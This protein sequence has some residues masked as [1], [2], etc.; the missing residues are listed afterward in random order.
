MTRVADR[1]SRELP[2]H[3]EDPDLWFADAPADLERAKELCRP[4][5]LRL[6]CLAAALRRH[7]PCGV[8]GGEILLSGQIVAHKRGRGRP[9]KLVPAAA[10]EE[11]PARKSA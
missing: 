7:E 11:Y 5:P 1:P 2:C 10:A 3:E 6:A 8:W 4:C 9:R